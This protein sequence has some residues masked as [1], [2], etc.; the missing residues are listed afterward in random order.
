MRVV[1]SVIK[2]SLITALRTSP[3]VEKVSDDSSETYQTN[4]SHRGR[5]L[6]TPCNAKRA[7]QSCAQQAVRFV[8]S[9]TAFFFP[10][11]LSSCISIVST[12]EKPEK[13]EQS[14]A[15]CGEITVLTV[16]L[17]SG[18][19]LYQSLCRR[20]YIHA[21]VNLPTTKRKPLA[22]VCCSKGFSSFRLFCTQSGTCHRLHTLCPECHTPIWGTGAH[23]RRSYAT[24][25]CLGMSR[26]YS[27]VVLKQPTSVH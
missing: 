2:E 5:L 15:A 27:R 19:V 24:V 18:H 14:P 25:L 9:R 4:S 12:P 23:Q 22:F 11:A 7:E 1:R 17:S 16:A 10:F 3:L 26:R 6:L 8:A 13:H 20:R 21:P